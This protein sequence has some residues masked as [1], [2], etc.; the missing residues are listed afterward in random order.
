MTSKL[1][2]QQE[3]PCLTIKRPN[4]LPTGTYP[5]PRSA[6]L[7]R[8][9]MKLIRLSSKN[10]PTPTIYS[11]IADGVHT[12]RRHWVVIRGK[13]WLSNRHRCRQIVTKRILNLRHRVA[14]QELVQVS[15]NENDC[16][17]CDSRIGFG[18]LGHLDNHNVCGNEAQSL[19]N[20]G[21]KKGTLTPWATAW[22][23]KFQAKLSEILAP[24]SWTYSIKLCLFK[25][26]VENVVSQSNNQKPNALQ[27]FRN[28]FIKHHSS[29]EIKKV[30]FCCTPSY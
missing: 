14:Q 2:F 12:V 21:D 10:I 5:S 17:S 13:S 30:P 23:N 18:T 15:N 3:R 24:D 11:L 16:N 9:V 25:R 7:W 8:S 28:D 29:S 27:V 6:S 20:N 4:C 1:I 22:C 19:P 26:Q